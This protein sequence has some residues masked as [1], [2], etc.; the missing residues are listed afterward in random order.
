MDAWEVLHGE[1]GEAGH[2]CDAAGCTFHST[3]QVRTWLC[4]VHLLLDVLQHMLALVQG[5]DGLLVLASA[6]FTLGCF[7]FTCLRC[8]SASTM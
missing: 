2:T 4:S 6:P 5:M 1:A 8:Q 7:L 3:R